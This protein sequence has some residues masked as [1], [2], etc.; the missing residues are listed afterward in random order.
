VSLHGTPRAESARRAAVRQGSA[1]RR[2][3]GGR[4]LTKAERLQLWESHGGRCH[5]CGRPVPI[6]LMH[7]E[8]KVALANGGTD[9]LDNLA[10]AHPDC[11]LRKGSR[12]SPRKKGLK[13]SALRAKPKTRDLPED[14]F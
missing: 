7:V 2:A 11:N 14:V 3:R 5:L 1:I 4:R 10:P 6:E 12:K 13:R 8:H 9:G